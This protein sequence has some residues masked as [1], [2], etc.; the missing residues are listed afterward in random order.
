M[1]NRES[2]LDEHHQGGKQAN[3]QSVDDTMMLKKHD[4]KTTV[5]IHM[6]PYDLL[7]MRMDFMI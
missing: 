2:Y 3:R 7:F 4:Q 6:T 1:W 5:C